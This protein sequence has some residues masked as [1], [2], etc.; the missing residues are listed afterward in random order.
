MYALLVLTACK[1]TLTIDSS[2]DSAPPLPDVPDLDLV[3]IDDDRY[4]TPV[5][6]GDKLL[7]HVASRGVLVALDAD[8]PP[9]RTA[10]RHALR[11]V[12][13]QASA[14]PRLELLPGVGL[15]VAGDALAGDPAYLLD[16]A[17]LDVLR[18]IDGGGVDAVALGGALYTGYPG[19]WQTADRPN[20]SGRLMSVAAD[21][22]LSEAVPRLCGEFGFHCGDALELM[23]GSVWWTDYQGGLYTGG[24]AFHVEDGELFDDAP[25]LRDGE[26]AKHNR[27]RLRALTA[28]Q[29]WI[30]GV[31]D[32]G[33]VLDVTTGD[34]I[35]YGAA[36][37]CGFSA[38]E[39]ES[40]HGSSVRVVSLD[41]AL[42]GGGYGALR[43]EWLDGPHEGTAQIVTLPFAGGAAY[44][45]W[46]IAAMGPRGLLAVTCDGGRGLF[47]GRVTG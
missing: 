3:Q 23:A 30:G 40:Y 42:G 43:V 8:A 44:S 25:A 5:F 41:L 38:V 12:A 34:Q 17:T 2:P 37:G 21:G 11:S 31:V 33:L 1:G 24:N 27:T 46:P 20:E 47:W 13:L 36:E 7:L 26:P 10:W 6:N 4:G 9:E 15:W 39:G 22:T 19:V 18:Q 28:S 45:C 35:T 14:D 16:P 29:I 32:C